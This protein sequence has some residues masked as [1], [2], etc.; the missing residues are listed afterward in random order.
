MTLTEKRQ[1]RGQLVEQMRAVQRAADAE[2]R[3]MTAEESAKFDLIAEEQE[4]LGKEIQAEEQRSERLRAAEAALA[5]TTDSGAR[6]APAGS[7]GTERRNVLV[8]DEY[9]SAVDAYLRGEMDVRDVRTQIERR[10]ETLQVGLFAKA[11]ALVMPQQMA[12]GLIKSVDDETFMLSLANVERLTQAESLGIGTLDTDPDDPDWTVEL[13]TG[14]QGDLAVGKRELRPHPLAK[15]VLVSNTLLRRTAGGAEALVNA[16]L[17]YKFGIAIEKAALTGDGMQK[18]LGVFTASNDGIPTSRDVTT[19]NTA[20]AIG[21]DNLFEAK[22]SI[23]A[24]YWPRLTAI[25]HRDAVKQIRKLKDGNGQY[26]WQPGLQAGQPDRIIDTTFKVSEYAP[27][28]FTASKYVGIFGDFK[29]GYTFAVALDM[30]IQRLAE[31]YAETN[32]T[33]FIGRAELD[34]MPV[35]AEAFARM[36]L[37]A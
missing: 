5:Q 17:A 37:A 22:Y 6:P 26:L 29:A 7:G 36:K 18:P 11:G 19:G 23:K 10:A 24:A 31:L 16:R 12:Q 14:S 25:F 9:R 33:G 34:G 15:R 20:T 3:S 35:L 28:T 8:T 2:K 13:K 32:K 21:A 30:T 4:K 27:N 1:K